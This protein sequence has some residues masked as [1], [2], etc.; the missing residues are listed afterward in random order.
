MAFQRLKNAARVLQ[1]KIALRMTEV[2]ALIKPALRV[3]GTLLFIPAGEITAYRFV[4]VVEILA[5]KTGSVGV[6]DDVLAK[7]KLVL[8]HV[9]Y[10][11]AKE[12][13]VSPGADRHP[14]VGQGAGPRKARI[15]M[16]DRRA[17]FLRLHHPAEADRMRLGHGRALDQ[18]AIRA[19]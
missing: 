17:F 19:G 11:P 15:D 10:E 14:D 12:C 6:M 3:V 16:N 5:Q 4:R 2:L 7:K 1:R 18:N 13:D 9:P 8:D